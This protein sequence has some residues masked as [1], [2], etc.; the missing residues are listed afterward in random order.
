MAIRIVTDSTADLPADLA[1]QW[2]LSVLPAYLIL[3]DVSYKGTADISD[4]E[5]YRRLVSDPRLPTTSQPTAA[6][7]E[8]VYRGLLEQGHEVLSIHLSAKLSGTLNSAN[9]AKSALGDDSP[10]EIVDSG[11][12]SIALGL[13]VLEAAERAQSGTSLSELAEGTRARMGSHNAFFV[14]DTLEYLA[15]G[16]RVGKA[17]S[18]MG[19]L[20]SIKPIL[21]F[22]G[23][24]VHPVDR[25]RTM[26]KA[27]NR[28]NELVSQ[29][30]QL[31]RLAVIYST[32]AAAAQKLRDSLAN[33][34]Q[35]EDII[36]TRFSPLL[37]TYVGPN[38]LGAAYSLASG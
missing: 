33:L 36:L 3:D 23:G 32:D 11:M 18:V 14:L 25:P 2:N 12:A 5:F 20:L 31:D 35:P 28:L 22:E 24:E 21:T 19:S 17:Q 6:D 26:T 10:I 13:A 38:A 7:F 15:R 27:L 8:A 34:A 16:G 9:Q 29:Q 4:D 1:E 37:G 30:G